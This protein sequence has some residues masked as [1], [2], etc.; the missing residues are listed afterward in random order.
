[1]VLTRNITGDVKLHHVIMI[2]FASFLHCKVIVFLFS[3]LILWKQVTKSSLS[4]G[5]RD[6]T[7]FL[8]RG[9]YICMLQ[10]F[11]CKESVSLLSDLSVYI[12]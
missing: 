11:F 4:W 2:A 7:S 10:K 5:R 6:S 3:Y 12:C 1:M 8:E 9:L